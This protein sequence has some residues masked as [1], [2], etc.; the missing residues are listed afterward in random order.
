MLITLVGCAT[1]EKTGYLIF[2][3]D[4]P[5]GDSWFPKGNIHGSREG[6]SVDFEE[7]IVD[8]SEEFGKPESISLGQKE[9]EVCMEDKGWSLLEQIWMEH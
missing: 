1:Y 9:I 6:S 4:M 2:N 5:K 7:C 3:G 8:L